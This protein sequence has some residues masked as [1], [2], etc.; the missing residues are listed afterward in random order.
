[1]AVTT[2]W[3]VEGRVL[4]ITASRVFDLGEIQPLSEQ[5]N[6]MLAVTASGE[7]VHIIHDL[8]AV[9]EPKRALA[10]MSAISPHLTTNGLQ[11]LVV[12]DKYWSLE[13][14]WLRHE[15]KNHNQQAITSSLD[16][17]FASLQQADSTLPNLRAAF[18]ARLREILRQSPQSP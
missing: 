18:R 16:E 6:H 14:R 4:F 10:Y 13:K 15:L 9:D 2:S 8:R 3:L 1:M 5:I 12:S 17:A 11:A 7:P